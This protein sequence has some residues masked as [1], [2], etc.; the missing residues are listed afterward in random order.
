[1]ASSV[2]TIDFS[3]ACGKRLVAR[4]F[5][6]TRGEVARIEFYERRLIGDTW[7]EVR[8]SCCPFCQRDFSAATKEEFEKEL[9]L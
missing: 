3:C 6:P 2:K 7:D 1:M 4:L 5:E 8:I 9:F